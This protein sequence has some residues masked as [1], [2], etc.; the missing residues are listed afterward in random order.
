MP[1]TR[2]AAM[3][4]AAALLLGAPAV[5]APPKARPAPPPAPAPVETTTALRPTGPART[6]AGWRDFCARMT[7]ECRRAPAPVRPLPLDAA[8]WATL[9]EVDREVNASL[10]LTTDW[11]HW[12]VIDRWDIPTDGHGDCEDYVLAKRAALIRR[13]FPA[14]ALLITIVTDRWGDGHAVLTVTTD[15][16]DFV[17]DNKATEIRPWTRSEL[18]W[19]SR[20][21]RE[22]PDVW[23]ALDAD[24]FDP[25]A[26]R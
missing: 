2:R 23:L 5:A 17:L 16:G 21:S 22:D 19:I 7:G 4:I 6:P 12:G 15:H 1:N 10:R 20:Q 24:A 8:A 18:H 26:A 9:V 25:P 3:L 11:D 13:G 14:N